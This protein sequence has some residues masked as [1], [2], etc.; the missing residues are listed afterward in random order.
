MSILK[1]LQF[2][3]AGTS[4]KEVAGLEKTAGECL[5]FHSVHFLIKRINLRCPFLNCRYLHISGPD[6]R[7]SGARRG[8]APV[9]N[10]SALP[11]HGLSDR[12][13][14]EPSLFPVLD[15]YSWRRRRGSEPLVTSLS[16]QQ[17]SQHPTTDIAEEEEH[18]VLEAGSI[19]HQ[20]GKLGSNC[21]WMHCVLCSLGFPGC[22]NRGWYLFC[23][24]G[25]AA[26]GKS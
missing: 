16:F 10:A 18:A 15:A 6:N 12:R 8:S 20:Q 23:R 24:G 7:S 22:S 14:S 13:G 19:L 25:V 1:C 21:T 11:G 2:K 3:C 26:T 9:V 17:T 5:N 4:R